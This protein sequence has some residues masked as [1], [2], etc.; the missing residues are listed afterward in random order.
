MNVQIKDFFSSRN[1]QSGKKW[2]LFILFFFSIFIFFLIYFLVLNLGLWFSV[3][4]QVTV[5]NSHITTLLL[6][7]CHMIT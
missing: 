2:T 6:L 5:T 4:S 3:M 1:F 7:H